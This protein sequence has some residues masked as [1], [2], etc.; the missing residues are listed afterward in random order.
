MAI[1]VDI[2]KKS[3]NMVVVADINKKSIN[4][5]KSIKSNKKSIN[6]SISADIDSSGIILCAFNQRYLM[7]IYRYLIVPLINLYSTVKW[8]SKKY[9]KYHWSIMESQN[10]I[11]CLLGLV[12][13][14]Y[15]FNVTL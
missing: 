10:F 9:Y 2:N 15:Q 11:N 14:V 13:Y 1:S 7:T 6:I 4:M 12:V 8:Y 5:A 3:I